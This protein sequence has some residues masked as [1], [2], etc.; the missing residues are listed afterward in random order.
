MRAH[1]QRAI[2]QNTGVLAVESVGFQAV[3]VGT[4]GDSS[5]VILC[6]DLSGLVSLTLQCHTPLPVMNK[7]GGSVGN[8]LC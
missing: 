7:V 3:V 5:F 8:R 4:A 1:R 2:P 6:L